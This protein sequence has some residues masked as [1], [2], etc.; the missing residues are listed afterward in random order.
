[1]NWELFR[2]RKDGTFTSTNIK[3]KGTGIFTFTNNA[4]EN[5][6]KI[7]G[8]LHS[9]EGKEPMSI[10]VKPQKAEVSKQEVPKTKEV[11]GVTLSYQD[12]S[13]ISKALNYM[14]QLRA[15]A[16]FKNMAGEKVTFSLWED[17]TKG[18][19]HNKEN[20]LIAFSGPVQ[21]DSKE[22]ARWDFTLLSTYALFAMAREDDNKQHEYY[23][24]VE[25]NG[26]SKASGNVNVNVDE[27]SFIPKIVINGYTNLAFS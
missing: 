8:Y 26:N 24:L 25:Y 11:L 7:E 4:Y 6:Y 3:K 23:V 14:D 13:K 9:P 1:M 21:I 17:D 12:G 16:K 5:V 2:Q 18:A 10:I 19:G 27:N 22:N 15:V 20:I